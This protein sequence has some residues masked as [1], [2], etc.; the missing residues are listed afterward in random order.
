MKLSVAFEALDNQELVQVIRKEIA[1]ALLEAEEVV[2]AA[3]AANTSADQ[4]LWESA[5][6]ESGDIAVGMQEV[7][8]E[9]QGQNGTGGVSLE[10]LAFA[11][12]ALT[13]MGRRSNVP[14]QL[15]IASLE[16]V[17]GVDKVQVSTNVLEALTDSYTNLTAKA[18]REAQ[19]LG[20]LLKR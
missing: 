5:S 11:Q 7:I 15:S 20:E 4:T 16:D 10:S 19:R 14:V 9:L 17:A 1:P 13:A 2:L 8:T 12:V 3:S 6:S 18:S